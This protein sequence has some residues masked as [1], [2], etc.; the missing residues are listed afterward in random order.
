MEI[1]IKIMPKE[2]ANSKL[3]LEVSKAIEVVITLVKWAIFP[4]TIIIAPTSDIA[5]PNPARMQV[6]NEYR[7]SQVIV[8]IFWLILAF[9]DFNSSSY[10]SNISLSTW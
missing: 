3:P 1:N 8:I 4:P 6:N 9:N 7:A 10:S 5:L 2:I